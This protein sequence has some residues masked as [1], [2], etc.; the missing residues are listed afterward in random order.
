[1]PLM[2]KELLS[3]EKVQIAYTDEELPPTHGEAFQ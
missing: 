1:M 2:E 3:G